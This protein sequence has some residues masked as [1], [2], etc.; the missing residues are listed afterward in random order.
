MYEKESCT[1]NLPVVGGCNRAGCQEYRGVRRKVCGFS[2]YGSSALGL[3][4][5]LFEYSRKSRIVL[6]VHR[7]TPGLMTASGRYGHSE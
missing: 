7:R 4:R 3:N 1:Q 5:W 2:A 6:P